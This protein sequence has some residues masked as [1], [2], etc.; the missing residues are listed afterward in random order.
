V[1]RPGPWKQWKPDTWMGLTKL[2]IHWWIYMNFWFQDFL[3][4]R[5]N[6][7]SFHVSEFCCVGLCGGSFSLSTKSHGC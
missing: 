5:Y 7:N 1:T 3:E 6:L 4:S 2:L